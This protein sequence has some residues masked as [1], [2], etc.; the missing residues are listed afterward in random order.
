SPGSTNVVAITC[1]VTDPEGV[2]AVTLAYQVVA[3]GR[4]IPATLPLTTAQ[5]N[6]LNTTPL[7]NQLNPE[8]E[9]STNW[10]T[11][12][13]HDDGLNGDETPGDGVYTVLL[14]PQANRS[15]V[16]YRI[17]CSDSL[18]ASRRA[19]FEDDPSLNFAYFVYDGIPAYQG[20][21]ASAL[22]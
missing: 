12:S 21:P 13:M 11:V 10:T 9:A 7:T 18:G 8:F 16:R 19:P 14:A 6:N 15:L 1:K 20:I 22:Q 3:P 4:F 2:A 17:T 5:L